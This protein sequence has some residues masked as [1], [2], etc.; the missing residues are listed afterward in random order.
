MDVVDSELAGIGGHNLF[1]F[2]FS[3]ALVSLSSRIINM[4][5]LRLRKR[6]RTNMKFHHSLMSPKLL[7]LLRILYTNMR[8]FVLSTVLSSSLSMVL[9]SKYIGGLGIKLLLL[10]DLTCAD[11]G[12]FWGN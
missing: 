10:L 1:L 9:L 6:S 12:R 5:W 8:D 2:F 4:P 7:L 11:S 3:L